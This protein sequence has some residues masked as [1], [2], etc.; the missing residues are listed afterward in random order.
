M[1]TSTLVLRFGYR[2]VV[3][4]EQ[5]DDGQVWQTCPLQLSLLQLNEVAMVPSEYAYVLQPL[6]VASPSSGKHIFSTKVP[7]RRETTFSTTVFYLPFL[8]LGL[9]YSMGG[10]FRSL[11]AVCLLS[12]ALCIVDKRCKIG[13]MVCI[14]VEQ[15]SGVAFSIC[16][17]FDPLSNWVT[18]FNI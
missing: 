13:I 3:E 10:L 12:A 11:C 14:E 1:R 18:K 4:A 16:T 6:Y 8:V 5:T 2:F 7:V 15:E 9:C 17:M